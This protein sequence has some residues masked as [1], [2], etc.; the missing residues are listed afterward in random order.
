MAKG[1]ATPAALAG[2]GPLH[3]SSAGVREGPTYPPG[4]GGATPWP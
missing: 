2:A 3:R 4:A 1:E